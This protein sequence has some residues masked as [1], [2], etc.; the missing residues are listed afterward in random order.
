MSNPKPKPK[1]KAGGDGASL[2]DRP[3]A[4]YA[5]ARTLSGALAARIAEDGSS[6]PLPPRTDLRNHSP[7]GFEWGYGGSGPAQLALAI[8]ADAAG[9]RAAREHYQEFKREV[10][11]G[12]G[13]P[14]WEL[15][16]ARVL[17]WLAARPD[18]T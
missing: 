14:R 16:R 10:I 13:G 8:L 4:R 5:G 17:Q 1:P 3:A 18:R 6:R 9:P 15:T 7:D 12:F 11:A 2:A